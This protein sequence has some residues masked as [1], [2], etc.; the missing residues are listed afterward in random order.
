MAPLPQVVVLIRS[1]KSPLLSKYYELPPNPDVTLKRFFDTF[2]RPSL[3]EH[4]GPGNSRVLCGALETVTLVRR[5]APDDLIEVVSIETSFASYIESNTSE[6][7]KAT[8]ICSA[9]ANPASDKKAI[10]RQ[11]VQLN[12]SNPGA[13]LAQ[14]MNSD[15]ADEQLEGTFGLSSR[16]AETVM[17][18]RAF[19]KP[20]QYAQDA[21]ESK[22]S[23][24]VPPPRA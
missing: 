21:K 8:F 18:T 7:K 11:F 16:E 5:D 3:P 10:M 15:V 19:A 2:V 17:A 20:R 9:Q 4:V 23:A 24:F 1:K 12:P 6:I 22:I 14:A 13:R